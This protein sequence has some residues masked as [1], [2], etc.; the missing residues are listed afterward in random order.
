MGKVMP[1]WLRA[2]TPVSPQPLTPGPPCSQLSPPCSVRFLP[3]LSPPFILQ[4]WRREL[5]VCPGRWRSESCLVVGVGGAGSP[6]SGLGGRRK[7]R[8]LL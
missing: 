8:A 4:G 6:G 7:G 5:C 2:L 1:A 3:L